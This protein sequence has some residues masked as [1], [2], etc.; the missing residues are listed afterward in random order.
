M[1]T[2][3]FITAKLIGAL[4]LLETW[5]VIGLGVSLV[6]LLTQ[7]RTIAL[8]GISCTFVCIVGLSIFPIG[9]SLLAQFEATYPAEPDVEN[10]M[11]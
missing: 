3:F 8:F 9:N 2:A 7:K 6:S 11:A 5:I 1:D 10:V 4:L